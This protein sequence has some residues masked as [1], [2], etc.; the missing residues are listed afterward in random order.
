MPTVYMLIG[1]PGSGKTTWRENTIASSDEEFVVISQDDMID[2]FAWQNNLTY[3]EAFKIA[4]LHDFAKQARAD[5]RKAIAER[6][7]IIIDR[8]NMSKKTRASFLSQ[9]PRDYKIVGV[10]FHCD[11]A[12]L[13]KRI[14]DRGDRTGKYISSAV[15]ERMK[16][17]F[18]EPSLDE[19]QY[20]I[21]VRPSDNLDTIHVFD[22]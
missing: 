3:N 6:K 10:M 14:K 2:N 12:L 8:T 16:A 17:N 18:E 20:I 7:S 5:F 1:L 4:P 22:A 19:F 9:V 21:H 15:I 11:D 13:Y